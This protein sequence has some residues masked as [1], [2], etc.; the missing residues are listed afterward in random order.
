MAN[1]VKMKR[2]DGKE[3]DVHPDM[4]DHYAAGGFAVVEAAKPKGGKK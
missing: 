3:A 4:I 2:E 1:L